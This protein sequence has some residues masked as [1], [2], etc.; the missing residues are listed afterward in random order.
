MDR[1]KRKKHYFIKFLLLIFITAGILFYS[2]RFPVTMELLDKRLNVILKILDIEEDFSVFKTVSDFSKNILNNAVYWYET[3]KEN[4]IT[5]KIDVKPI[6]AIKITCAAKFPL[7]TGRITSGFGKRDDP[8]SGKEDI[9]G[10]IDI[11]AAEGSEVFAAWPGKIAETGSDKIYGKY[12][13]LEHSEGFFTKYCHLSE[14][15]VMENEFVLA[16]DKIG[17]AG[18]T[19]RSTGSH[20]HFE[21]IVEGKKVDPLE[22]FNI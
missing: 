1:N 19:G 2:A 6:T 4:I 3:A 22:C 16:K 12:I 13:L 9:H 14:I 7:G 10:G 17:R 15:S 8:F 20:L 5:N 21:V 18:N 11:A